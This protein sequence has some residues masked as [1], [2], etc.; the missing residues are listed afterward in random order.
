MPTSTGT[1]TIFEDIHAE[2]KR[3]QAVDASSVEGFWNDRDKA[4]RI[5]KELKYWSHL[6]DTWAAIGE[7][8]KDLEEF[9]TLVNTEEKTEVQE[10]EKELA[11]LEADYKKAHLSLFLNGP[12]DKND[13]I[14]VISAGTG[15]VEA[16][17]WAE[18]LLRMYLRYCEKKGFSFAVTEKQIGGEAG[19]KKAVLEVKGMLAYGYLKSEHGVHRLVRLS[20]FNAKNLRQTSFALVEV[21]P[22]LAEDEGIVI[23]A[24]DLRV[25]TF[26]SSGPGGQNVNKTESAV[27]FTHIPTGIVVACQT[28]RSQIQNRIQ[29]M[30]I[31]R[32]KLLHRLVE[33][34]K[35]K[36]EELKGGYKEVGF[37]NQIRSY[38]FQ[39]YTLVKDHRTD[40]ETSQVHEVMDG[41]LDLFV[42][43]Y[44]LETAKPKA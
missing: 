11:A 29:G 38:T 3:Q 19:I 40:A 5:L 34:K 37:G 39:P 6:I 15:G 16:Q 33:E 32:A 35:E 22:V 25:D 9:G 23:D 26:R 43:A 14:L 12:Y 30:A 27:R 42:E 36:V 17:D 1:S 28:E 4:E 8:R 21:L 24:K 7:K 2:Q 44:L 20:P 10:Y 18:M 13:A 31:L 41:D